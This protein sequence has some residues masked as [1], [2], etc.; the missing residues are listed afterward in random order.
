MSKNNTRIFLVIA[1][2]V[3]IV[4]FLVIILPGGST[5]ETISYS[6]LIEGVKRDAS[7][8]NR[9][10]GIYFVGSYEVNVLYSKD[11][12]HMDEFKAG[13]YKSASSIV[14]YRDNLAVT[15]EEI[16]I[17]YP[18]MERPYIALN[19]PDSG[20]FLSYLFPALTFLLILGLAVLFIVAMRKGNGASGALSFAKTNAKVASNIKVRFNDVAG[21][22]EEKEELKEVV[23]FLKSPKKFKQVGARIPKGVL[24]VGNPGTGKTLFAKAVAGEADVPFFSISGSDFVEMFV[25]VGA[26]RVRHLFSQ[27]KRN[28]PCIVFIDE[29]DAVGRKRGAGLGGG[30]DEREQTLN[31]LL[32]QMDGFDENDGV[33]IMAATNRS[34]VLDPALLRP[35]RFDRHIYV[36]MPDVKGREG[37]FKVHTRNKPIAPDIDFQQLARITTGF[38]GAD[39]ENLLN[40]AAILAARDDRTVILMCDIK[41]GIN[42]V[43]LGPQKRSRV[44]TE[45]DKRTTAYHEAGHAIVGYK[46]KYCDDIQ[47]V[48]IVP[49]GPAA[50]YT[51]SKSKSDDQHQTKNKFNDEIAMVLG[52]RA[53]EEI[54]ILDVSSGAAQDLKVSTNIARRMVT[55]YGMSDSLPN[56]FFGGEQ[57]VFI[58]RDYQT[59]SVHSESIAT[60]I[61]TEIKKIIDINYNR[62]LTILKENINALHNTVKLL[63]EQETIYGDELAL[64]LDG[65]TCDEV[66]KYIN[67]KKIE[68]DRIAEERRIALEQAYQARAQAAKEAMKKLENASRDLN[69]SQPKFYTMNSVIVPESRKNPGDSDANKSIN[70]NPLSKTD[71]SSNSTTNNTMN[72]THS[73][74]FETRDSNLYRPVGYKPTTPNSNQE[75]KE[76][77]TQIENDTDDKTD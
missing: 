77:D 28:Q 70:D 67:D 71:E 53:A 37:I 73:S 23:E 27:A 49:R 59:Q 48:S 47:E 9:I 25:G 19:D 16:L 54:V 38:S 72:I 22:D 66:T 43:L 44:V 51:L 58:G 46:L 2:I 63:F 30:N 50:G 7:D 31:Q 74:E 57:E 17:L 45:K 20:S 64:I 60:I 68:Q 12:K 13:K 26:S 18:T 6:E 39:I 15:L 56:I 3:L 62:A 75:S 8:E 76:T 33:V 10:I 29:I 24:L 65:K 36:N 5:T 69:I 35:G 1:V 21:A 32:V 4:V 40:E 41:E 55:D 61:D 34:D 11:S 42:K 52:G 14:I